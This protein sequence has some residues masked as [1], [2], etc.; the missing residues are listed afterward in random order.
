MRW[1]SDE[2]FWLWHTVNAYDTEPDGGDVVLDYV[3][4]SRLS[5]GT[6]ARTDSPTPQAWS[7]RSS[8]PWRARC[9]A[10]CW[11]TRGWSC[12]HGRP[13]DRRRHQQLAVAADSGNPDLLPGEFDELRWYDGRDASGTSVVWR[14]GNLSV[15]E[16]VFAPVPGTAPGEGGYW[17]TYATDRTDASSWL[18]VIPA[19][20][21]A[22]GP[23]ARVRIP[24]TGA[25]RPARELAAHAGVRTPAGRC[26]PER[27]PSLGHDARPLT[28]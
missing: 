20:D 18:L 10:P 17:M 11:T 28:R 3:Q 6:P 15:G 23:V 27:P 26:R 25:P 9:T 7:A 22:S 14:A 16:P 12:P 24:G 19:D 8:T 21:P 4:W 2:A 13:P 5:M 1:A